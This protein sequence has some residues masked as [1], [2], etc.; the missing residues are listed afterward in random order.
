MMYQIEQWR[1]HLPPTI[2]FDAPSELSPPESP[3]ELIVSPWLPARYLLA[4]WHIGR[5]FLHRIL[6]QQDEPSCLPLVFNLCSHLFG[7]VV[8]MYCFQMDAK[9]LE[10]LP[11][12]HEL[13]TSLAL[14][15]LQDCAPLSPVIARDLRVVK[16]LCQKL[17]NEALSI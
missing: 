13:F 6:A 17:T 11:P 15:F 10:V 5:P 3:L 14:E 7:Q 2:A 12:D 1:E 16:I 8:L 4:K 9:F